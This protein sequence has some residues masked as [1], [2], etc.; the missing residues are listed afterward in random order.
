MEWEV[1]I[2]EWLQSYEG[3]FTTSLGKALAFLGDEKGL[4]IMILAVMFCYKKE[5]GK[6]SIF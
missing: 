1:K 3:T 2:I 6:K 5:S 4:L